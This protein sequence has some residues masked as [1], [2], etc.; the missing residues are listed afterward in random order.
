MSRAL[1]SAALVAVL[2]LLVVGAKPSAGTDAEASDSFPASG[3]PRATDW[4]GGTAQG[5][6]AAAIRYYIRKDPV[7]RVQGRTYRRTAA[8]TPVVEI[9]LLGDVPPLPGSRP[10]KREAL[11]RCPARATMRPVVWAVVF[12]ESVSVICC[13]RATFFAGQRKPHQWFVF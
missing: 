11:R 3:C 2:A 12:H 6:A 1:R 8:N 13:L 10:L 7:I 4:G 5:A 9:V